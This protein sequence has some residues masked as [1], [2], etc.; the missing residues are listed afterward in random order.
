[1]RRVAHR[2]GESVLRNMPTMLRPTRIRQNIV[3]VVALRAHRIRPL[4]TGI[5]IR[6]S[7][8]HR[9]AR[10]RGLAELVIPFQN[11]GVARPMRPVRSRSAKF[12]V[13]IT[14]VAVDAE[15]AHA[16]KPGGGGAILIQHVC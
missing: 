6:I 8:R 7:I 3:Q 11:V 2:A 5:R 10:R 13:V 1:M 12:P 15:D 14:I 9:S 4:R 16:D